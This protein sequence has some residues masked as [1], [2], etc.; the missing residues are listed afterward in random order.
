[1]CNGIL[2]GTAETLQMYP[3][4]QAHVSR[5]GRN[6]QQTRQP[7]K[8]T[9][10]TFKIKALKAIIKAFPAPGG[11]QLLD[12]PFVRMSLLLSKLSA[13]RQI[14]WQCEKEKKRKML[15]YIGR[16]SSPYINKGKGD[17]LAQNGREPSP[18]R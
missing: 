15:N 3:D 17:T 6:K 14:S 1:M 12:V 10:T 13:P 7:M 16:G 5:K 8:L 18:P 4:L 2:D 9:W 11:S